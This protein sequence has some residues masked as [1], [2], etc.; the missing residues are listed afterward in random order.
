MDYKEV[1]LAR[2]SDLRDGER[3]A[4]PGLTARALNLKVSP[5]AGTHDGTLMMSSLT[6][7]P[8]RYY[9]FGATLPAWKSVAVRRGCRRVSA[10]G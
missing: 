1:P 2:A 10:S 8:Y 4:G 5:P 6:H 9:R 7:S 3:R